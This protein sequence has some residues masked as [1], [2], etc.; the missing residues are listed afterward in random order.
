[1]GIGCYGLVSDCER[2]PARSHSPHVVCVFGISTQEI[3]LDQ[4]L[5]GDKPKNAEPDEEGVQ[6]TE[7]AQQ[8]R[9][10]CQQYRRV[11]GM[12]H[13][14][15]CATAHQFPL[16]GNETDITAKAKTCPN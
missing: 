2:N 16:G 12:A 13:E 8:E 9:T 11:H 5:D 15:I 14:R 10:V 6:G 7:C 4:A 3:F 1:M